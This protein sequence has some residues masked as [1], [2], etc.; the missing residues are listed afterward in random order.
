MLGL[1]GEFRYGFS[2]QW[3][4]ALGGFFGFGKDK[5]DLGSLGEAE[6]SYSAFGLRLG[7][8][9][10][11]NVTDMLGVYMGPGFEFASAKSKVKDTSAPFDEDN[12]RAKSYSLD[13]RVGIIAKVGKNFG[14]NG[15]MGKKWS[16][17]KSSFDTDFGGGP[18]DVSFTRWLSSVNGW[19]GFVVLF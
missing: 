6:L 18:E 19:A 1:G 2:D 14:L 3:A 13:G 8:D 7:L 10:T 16:Y 4:L 17:V 5:A 15:S 12:P 11:I 9:H